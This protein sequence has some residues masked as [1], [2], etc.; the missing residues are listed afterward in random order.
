MG[1]F[2]LMG[3]HG[4]L[5]IRITFF[6]LSESVGVRISVGH[7][8]LCFLQFGS[9]VESGIKLGNQEIKSPDVLTFSFWR[10]KCLCVPL[11][12]TSWARVLTAHALVGQHEPHGA[13]CHG[14]APASRCTPL[15]VSTSLTVHAFMGQQHPSRCTPSWVSTNPHGS[16]AVLTVH[17]SWV[18]S[19]PHGSA[20]PLTTH[21]FRGQH[22]PWI[23]LP[24]TR[25][26]DREMTVSKSIFVVIVVQKLILKSDRSVSVGWCRTAVAIHHVY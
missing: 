25:F 5:S 15:W 2:R 4:G 14:E 20:R 1:S 17:A 13:R 23:P 8:Y 16:A 26:I 10:L 18:R 3:N 9:A 19:S 22:Q 11:L 21:A 6:F 12:S 7:L 24:W